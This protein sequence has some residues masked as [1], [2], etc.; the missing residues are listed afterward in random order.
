MPCFEIPPLHTGGKQETVRRARSDVPRHRRRRYDRKTILD[1]TE[2]MALLIDSGFPFQ[3]A[4]ESY[5]ETNTAS[6]GNLLG[7]EIL[8]GI[9]KGTMFSGIIASSNYGFPPIYGAFIRIGERTGSMERVFAFLAEYLGRGK[10]I[11]DKVLSAVIY[12]AAVLVFACLGLL[13]LSVLF[14]PSLYGLFEH[15]GNEVSVRIRTSA[16]A[17]NICTAFIWTCIGALVC[18][19]LIRPQSG[20]KLDAIL[21]RMPLIGKMLTAMETLAFSSAM[22][23]LTSNGLTAAEA[24][25]E[26]SK[27]VFTLPYKKAILCV[28]EKLM[29]GNSLS[30]AFKEQS[31]FP[32][33]LCQWASMG[34]R[35]G[36]IEKVFSHIKALYR[37]EIDIWTER[38]INYID[39][40]LIILVGAI[41]IC[42][43][44]VVIV[45][46]FSLYESIMR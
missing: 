5:I 39:P 30:S 45:P 13:A 36:D 8:A 15:M 2:S 31:I 16:A 37:H 32:L 19:A 9:K 25:E 44:V 14:L 35:A 3:N 46:L 6:K 22:E 41:L 43:V 20:G 40:F 18:A 34:E 33:I 11:R 21:L 38:F 7:A 24:I 4:L 42:I 28:R 23:A 29:K 1:F 26:A 27:A 17:M 10:R 12:P